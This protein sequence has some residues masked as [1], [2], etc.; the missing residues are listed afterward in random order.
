MK[1]G[2]LILTLLISVV[3]FAACIN[4]YPPA[5][6]TGSGSTSGTTTPA[7]PATPALQ[8]AQFEDR[9]W[10]L[11]RYGKEGNLQNVIAG[12]EANAKFDSSSG[13]VGGAAGCN[14][15]TASYQRTINKVSVFSIMTTMMN[16][17]MPAGI[18]A[19]ENAFKDALMGAES[20]RIIGGKL[21]INCSL[22]RLLIFE[23]K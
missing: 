14:S 19:Q 4:V 15:Y 7:T 6:D 18:M 22:N 5:T 23:P 12:K 11:E 16:C 20:C 2:I 21:E 10:V 3:N 1:A 13:K 8:L 9:T 17:P